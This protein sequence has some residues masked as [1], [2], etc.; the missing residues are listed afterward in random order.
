MNRGEVTTV[1]TTRIVAVA[2]L[3]LSCLIAMGVGS[4]G[5]TSTTPSVSASTYSTQTGILAGKTIGID[6]GHNGAN[7]SH[8]SIINRRVWDGR[9]YKA[10]NTTGT[11]TNAG[12]SESRFNYKVAQ[13]LATYLRRQG[14]RVVMTR[15]TNTGVGPCINRR[16]AI[17]NAAH[18]NVA[19]SIHADGA[20]SRGRGFAILEPV[21]SGTNNKVIKRSIRWGSVLRRSLLTNTVM[22]TSTYD[23]VNGI[24]FRRDLG[25]LNLTKVPTVLLE[26]GNMRNSRDARLLTSRTFQKRLALAIDRAIIQYLKG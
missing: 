5:A 21:A 24:K 3:G 2:C 23:G 22:P 26:S 12:Y 7:G 11:A 8:P 10:C 13:Y 20:P 18:A 14:A 4:A 15:T 9:E 6:P 16:A 17:I 1:R 19:I 25:A